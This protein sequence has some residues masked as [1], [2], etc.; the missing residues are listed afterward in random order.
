MTPMFVCPLL[1]SELQ[2]FERSRVS[3]RKAAQRWGP[4]MGPTVQNRSASRTGRI[5]ALI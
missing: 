4:V 1:L 3:P 2:L 5:I